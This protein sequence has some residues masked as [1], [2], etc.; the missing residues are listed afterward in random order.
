MLRYTLRHFNEIVKFLFGESMNIKNILVVGPLSLIPLLYQERKFFYISQK[1]LI[2]STL[3]YEPIL[4]KIYMNANFV[5]T[6]IYFMMYDLRG[7]L[8]PHKVVFLL[9]NLIRYEC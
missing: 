3:I 8:R 1:K 2:P 7:H 9:K 6:Q 4:M 5:K